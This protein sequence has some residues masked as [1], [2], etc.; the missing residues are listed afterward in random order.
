MAILIGAQL[1]QWNDCDGQRQ[2]DAIVKWLLLWHCIISNRSK[3][4]E[5]CTEQ[6]KNF[7]WN[8][9][10]VKTWT[11]KWNMFCVVR[12]RRLMIVLLKLRI[13]ESHDDVFRLK[14]HS[15]LNIIVNGIYTTLMDWWRV[16][17][18]PQ[19]KPHGFTYILMNNQ[20]MCE[21]SFKWTNPLQTPSTQSF[22]RGKFRTHL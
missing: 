6:K 14:K 7:Q 16:N 10:I 20:E 18:H 21:R 15:S 3:I 2:N 9:H 17:T 19:K 13:T 5:M 4:D 1:V 8:E 22:S 12:V 11:F